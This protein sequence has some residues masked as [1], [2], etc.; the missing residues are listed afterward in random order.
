MATKKKTPSAQEDD[1]TTRSRT[2][3]AA[4]QNPPPDDDDFD[5]DLDEMGE[6]EY[7][8][9]ASDAS[10]LRA[11]NDPSSMPLGPAPLLGGSETSVSNLYGRDAMAMGRASSPRL[12]AQ[13]TQFPTCSQLRVWRWENG[14]PVGLGAIDAEA[15]EED[16]V[17]EFYEAMPKL[18]QGRMMFKL[19]PI[20][21]RGEEMGKEL[22]VVISEHHAALQSIRRA[23]KAESEEASQSMNNQNNAPIYMPQMQDDSGTAY[24]SE[25]SRMFEKAVE[26]ADSRAQ[27][28]EHALLDERERLR[29][30]DDKRAQERIDLATNAA[31]GV[32]AITER[33]MRDESNRAER[34]MKSQTDQSQMLL[35][36]LTQ[37]FASAQAQQ[38]SISETARAA[39]QQRLE[40]ERQYSERGRMEQE[41][42]RKRDIAEME[43]RRKMEQTRLEDERKQL[44]DQREFE[45]KQLEL[46][47]ERERQELLTKLE[48]DKAEAVSKL[49]I[50]ERRLEKERQD[51]ERRVAQMREGDE[52]KL[53]LEKTDIERRTERERLEWEHRWKLEAEERDRRERL[54][55]EER[56]RMSAIEIERRK[57]E[58][59]E[60]ERRDRVEREERDRRARLDAEMA[61]LR[62]AEMERRARAEDEAARLR[63]AERQR[64]HDL[65]VKQMDVAAGRDREHAERMLQMQQLQMQEQRATLEARERREKEDALGRDADRL[66]QHER[67][68]KDVELQSQKDREHAERMMQLTQMQY[69]QKAFGGLGELIPKAKEW[70]SDLGLEPADIIQRVFTPESSGGG[71][72]GSSGWA[73]A[74]PKVLGSLAE[75]GKVAIEAQAASKMPPRQMQSQM[76]NPMM[77]QMQGVPQMPPMPQQPFTIPPGAQ[78]MPVAGMPG[79]MAV[80]MPAGTS[81]VPA[82]TPQ[83][84]GLLEDVIYNEPFPEPSAEEATEEGGEQQVTEEPEAPVVEPEKMT[85]QSATEAGLTMATQKRARKAVRTLVR[86]LTGTKETEW[87]GLIA[88]AISNEIGIY[89][90][91]KAV[92]IR[93]A[94][95][96]GGADEELAQRV[97]AAMRESGMIPSDVEYE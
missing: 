63:E 65:T 87:Q 30:E 91:V 46:R 72:G 52:R 59:E 1:A 27:A 90:Y 20:D 42:R 7:A 48:R 94:L 92:T 95:L 35:T 58:M 71:G 85:I 79:M 77:G 5:D 37:I 6:D 96:E 24:A 88:T 70:L 4:V 29:S 68:L 76:Q 38:H 34:S 82:G 17:R 73:D 80:Q 21:I 86:K 44:R 66:R 18:G 89:H 51:N 64:A 84:G 62:T 31:A 78:M 39:D 15:N 60:R 93:A 61:Q 54:A 26:A 28:L 57:M 36:T 23:K 11:L 8:E 45:M 43:E 25:M 9:A 53:Q 10:T 83:Q 74:I 2:R 55:R 40:Q 97:M 67:M 12:W 47:A 3:G 81:M 14:I 49:A 32:Q 75:M 56:E 33:M 22:S 19:R 16:F 13:A 41:E 69:Q 50:E